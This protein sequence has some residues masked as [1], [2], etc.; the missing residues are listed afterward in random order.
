LE[1]TN[2]ETLAFQRV[3]TFEAFENLEGLLFLCGRGEAIALGLQGFT[4]TLM[5]N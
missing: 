5:I 2:L 3:K 4:L 1:E